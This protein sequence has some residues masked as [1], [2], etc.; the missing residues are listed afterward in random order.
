MS[1]SDDNPLLDRLHETRRSFLALAAGI[2]P[3][4]HRYCARMTGSIADGED[5]VQD[6]LAR[7]YYE[8]SGLKE[9]P[10]L[11]A[12]LFRIAH[13]RALDFLR[14]YEH[15]MAEPIEAAEQLKAEMTGSP[16]DAVMREQ[17][18]HTAICRFLELAPAQRSCV[19]LKDVL[20]HSLEDIGQLL[21]LSVPAVKAA[22]HRGRSRLAVL[23]AGTVPNPPRQPSPVLSR[24]LELFNTR[25]WD[26]VRA[27][28]ADDV[29]LDVVSV[30]RRQGREKVGTYFANYAKASDWRLEHA[31]LDEREVL[32]VFRPAHEARPAYFIEAT[33]VR[34]TIAAI[35][36]YVH[37]PYITQEADFR[38]AD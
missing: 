8:L 5:V 20:G 27:M 30:D 13:N 9:V 34:N 18:M 37:V 23:S 17:A 36:D 10:A 15:R 24:Y 38:L 32:A 25:D 4:L 21:G 28:L 35:R 7:A 14:R 22:L 31:W 2:R 3:E 19:V 33:V 6:A 26:G 29:R 11:R 12:W 1:P 16:E